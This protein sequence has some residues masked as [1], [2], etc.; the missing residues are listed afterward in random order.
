MLLM[1]TYIAPL[2][3]QREDRLFNGGLCVSRAPL[4][5]LKSACSSFLHPKE[6]DTF[7]NLQHSKRQQSYLLGRYCAKQA[8]GA[9][10]KPTEPTRIWIENG[11]FQQPVVHHALH[12]GMQVSISHTDSLGA[13]L[14]FPEAHPMAI[15]IEMV[16]SSK[17]DILK[18]Q[19]TAAEISICKEEIGKLTLFWTAKEALSKVLR[20]GLTA[21]FEL[22]EVSIIATHVD[23]T[24]SHFKN[25]QQYQI[26]SFYI[27]QSVCSIV[28]PKNTQLNLDISKIQQLFNCSDDV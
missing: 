26:L 27:D 23:F 2:V 3:L 17:S 7:T 21:P 9:N 19:L 22:F 24:I 15:D 14:A 28:Y 16:C 10:I 12:P 5:D 6:H 4:K 1:P 11:V 25:F 20:C 18:T 13:A 8:I